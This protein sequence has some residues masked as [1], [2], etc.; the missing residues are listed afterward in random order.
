MDLANSYP[1]DG[2]RY[3]PAVELLTPTSTGRSP[4][5]R[6]DHTGGLDRDGDAGLGRRHGRPARKQLWKAV[7][8][9]DRQLDADVPDRGPRPAPPSH[10]HLDRD[11]DDRLGGFA[12]AS[13]ERSKAEGSYD[14]FSDSWA[15]TSLDGAPTAR[16]SHTAVGPARG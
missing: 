14:P 10:R 11:E 7:R 6:R 4:S 15:P 9:D 3:D 12:G 16:L 1:V 2:G 8:S 13:G 5:A